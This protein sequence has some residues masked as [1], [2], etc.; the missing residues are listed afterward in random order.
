MTFPTTATNGQITTVNNITYIYNAITNSWNR[1]PVTVGAVGNVTVATPPYIPGLVGIKTLNPS[2]SLDLSNTTDMLLMPVGNTAQRPSFGP[3]VTGAI[4]FNTT[5]GAPEWY[6]FSSNTALSAWQPFYSKWTPVI[7]TT[8]PS[9]YTIS[10]LVVAGGGGGNEQ[11]GGGGAGGLLSG[12][13]NTSPGISYTVVIGAGGVVYGGS[14]ANSSVIGTGINAIAI[15]GGGGNGRDQLAVTSAN[16]GSGGGGGGGSGGG[17]S[18]GGTGTAGQGNA[19]ANGNFNGGGANDGGGGGGGAGA[20][21]TGPQTAAYLN[22]GGVGLNSSITGTATYYAGGGGGGSVITYNSGGGAGG[23]GGGGGGTHGTTGGGGSS[24][25]TYSATP[26][27]NTYGPGGVNTGGGGGG[28]NNGTYQNGFAGGS[29]VVIISYTWPNQI[30][31]GGNANV[32][33][34]SYGS[35][36]ST[37]W[38]HKFTGSTT[39]TS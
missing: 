21:G 19:G 29:G 27:T 33:V 20:A 17:S 26:L 16:G 12:T 22:A 24:T 1:L 31:T 3:Q 6:Y 11:G 34:T 4:R 5:L 15:G 7:P 9:S 30:V 37:T 35:G 14:G 18:S 8:L 10:Y 2:A 23:L 13:F 28:G 38:V 32:T 25:G 39:F 36:A